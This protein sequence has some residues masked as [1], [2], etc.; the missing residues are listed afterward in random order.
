MSLYFMNEQE[1]DNLPQPLDTNNILE[2]ICHPDL[3]ENRQSNVHEY[4]AVTDEHLKEFVNQ[5][6]KISYKNFWI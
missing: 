3:N 2:V 5:F 6:E 1:L 4:N